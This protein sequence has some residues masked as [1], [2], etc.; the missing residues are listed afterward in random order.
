MKKVDVDA[1]RAF[2]R[3][4]NYFELLQLPQ[5]FDVDLVAL[6]NHYDEVR[7]S[8]HPDRFVNKSDVEKRVAVQYSALLNDA[9]QTLLSPVKRAIHLLALQGDCLNLEHETIKDEAFLMLQM[10]LRERIGEG[11]DMEAELAKASKAMIQELTAAFS[12]ED[13]KKARLLTQKLQFFNKLLAE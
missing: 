5:A 2:R 11:E 6:K 13:F 1:V 4:T 9:Y 8:I 12:V 10:K 3:M 7:K